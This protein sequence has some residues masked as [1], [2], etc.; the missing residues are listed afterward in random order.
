VDP[1]DDLGVDLLDGLESLADKSLVR[2]EP[3]DPEAPPAD[4][5]ARFGLHPLLREYALERLDESGERDMLEARHAAV[6]A[7]LAERLGADI[8]TAGGETSIRHLDHEAWNLRAAID[9]SL[10]NG[11]SDL[12]LRVM[13]STWRWFQQRGRL[14]EGRW[15]CGELLARPP[16]DVRVRIQGLAADGG[17]AYWMDDVPGA[18]RLYEER[19][20]LA[21]TT[22]DPGLIADG[23][24]DLGFVFMVEQDEANLRLHEQLALDGYIAAGRESDAIRARQAF[25]LAL[26]LSGNHA[27]AREQQE[28]ALE[29]FR[30]SDSPTEIADSQTLLSAILFRLDDPVGAWRSVIEAL[31]FFAAGNLSSGIARA[32]VMAAIIQIVH[33]DPD[34]GTRIAGATYELAR[35]QQVMLAPVTVLH[36]PDPKGLAEERLG[37]DRAGELL[38]TGAATPLA[39]VIDEVLAT[40]GTSVSAVNATV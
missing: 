34:L 37:P 12:G 22:G 39:D 29:S 25:V 3:I 26:F 15:L 20:A 18:H 10:A 13:G 1:D 31:R 35:E 24:Y 8:L 40:D 19:L 11:Q 30:L 16:G 38:A 33:G 21:E 32:M 14:R 5:E 4:Q 2:I 17:L 36:L 23:H 27:A 9:W 28:A 6:M 7:E